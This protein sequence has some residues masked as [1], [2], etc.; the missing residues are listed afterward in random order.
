MLGRACYPLG[1][2]NSLLE[3]KHMTKQHKPIMCTCVPIVV[4]G[5]CL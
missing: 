5:F 2:Y 3:E 4:L 1:I